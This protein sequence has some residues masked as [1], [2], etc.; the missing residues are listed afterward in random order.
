I[1]S[2]QIVACAGPWRSSGDWWTGKAHEWS[3][4]EWDVELLD[5]SIR[6]IYWDYCR[7]TWFLEGIYD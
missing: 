1:R 4:D 3:R 5:G 7:K 2:D 6:R